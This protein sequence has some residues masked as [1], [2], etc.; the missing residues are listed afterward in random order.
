MRLVL[1][2]FAVMLMALPVTAEDPADL[3]KKGNEAFMNGDFSKA[4]DFYSGAE[5]QL[6]ETPALEYNMAGALYQQGRYKESAD[7]Y[8][9]ALNSGD[10]HVGKQTHYNLGNT[11]FR[12]G[13]YQNAIK[14]YENAIK[15]DP[16]DMDAKFNLELARK[17]LKDQP[18]Q[19]QEDQQEQQE[20]DK[21]QEQEQQQNQQNQEQNEEQQQQQQQDEQQQQQDQPQQDEQQEQEEKEMSR[22]DAERI[23]NAM[24]DDEQE[25]QKKIKRPKGK[26][27]YTGKDW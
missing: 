27:T 3:V 23:L 12:M 21:E 9:K 20:Q 25:L 24:R 1:L 2:T 22:E 6:P 7:R 18:P 15:L 5:A 10:L 4:M 26:G 13:D 19:E 16:L 17:R 8:N 14:S 11:Y